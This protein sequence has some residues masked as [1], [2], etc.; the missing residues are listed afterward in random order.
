MN[1]CNPHFVRCIK[2][3]NT[4]KPMVYG[5][6]HIYTPCLH[7]YMH[8]NLSLVLETPAQSLSSLAD[9]AYVHIQ[10][11]YTGMLETT[12]IRRE[13]YAFRIPFAD[14]FQQCDHITSHHITSHHIT[15]HHITSHHA[16]FALF[17]SSNRHLCYAIIQST[18]SAISLLLLLFLIGSCPPP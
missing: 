12:R 6:R 11:G 10:L 16:N 14:F 9:S 8:T 13:G 5:T 1:A 2:P 4:K 18:V 7:A 17:H 3:S 15:S